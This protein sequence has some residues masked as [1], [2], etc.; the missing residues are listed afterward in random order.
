MAIFIFLPKIK[1]PLGSFL[2]FKCGQNLDT[3]LGFISNFEVP[4]CFNWLNGFRRFVAI[5]TMSPGMPGIFTLF[6]LQQINSP[7]P[8]AG[9]SL[10]DDLFQKKN[11]LTYLAQ[12]GP[13]LYK[14]LNAQWWRSSG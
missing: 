3:L 7:S 9:V 10:P 2:S 12:G 14:A 11:R 1:R 13:R 8:F 5:P 6:S 4:L